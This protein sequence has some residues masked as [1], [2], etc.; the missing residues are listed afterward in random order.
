MSAHEL[1]MALRAAYL[2]LH[3]STDASLATCGITADQFVVLAALSQ[4]KAVTQRELM[5]RTVSDPNTLR[6]MLILLEQSGLIRRRPHPT[7][8]RARSVALTPKGRRTFDL[9]WQQSEPVRARMASA[10]AVRDPAKLARQL[11]KLAAALQGM[12]PARAATSRPLSPRQ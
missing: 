9:A 12:L 6:A 10:V 8:G 5:S 3:R 7:D 4:G 2:A 1:A 11:R